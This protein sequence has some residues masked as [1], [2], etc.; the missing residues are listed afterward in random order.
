MTS[1]GQDW[2]D[3]AAQLR[4]R[5]VCQGPGGVLLVVEEIGDEGIRARK[6]FADS[7]SRYTW[8]QVGP[9][10]AEDEGDG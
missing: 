7:A 1:A 5:D 8:D 6:V 3:W 2:D 10:A 9:I 4:V